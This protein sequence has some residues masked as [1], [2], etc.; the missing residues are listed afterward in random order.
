MVKSV[1]TA[2]LKSADA[3]RTSSTLVSGT[4]KICVRCGRAGHSS[5]EC[6]YLNLRRLVHA[7]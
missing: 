4:K 2:D 3:S 7:K 5:H 1:D 6:P